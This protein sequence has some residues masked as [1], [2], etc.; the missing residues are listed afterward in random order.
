QAAV[1]QPASVD[2]SLGGTAKIDCSGSSSDEHGISNYGWWQ[3][4]PSGTLVALIY[5]N[6]KRPSGIPARF[7]GSYSGSTGT[8]TI[9]G[10]QAEDEVVYY[11]SGSYDGVVGDTEHW[12]VW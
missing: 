1:T 4:I 8:L 2:V 12:W 6:N 3:Q 11:C 10:V 7:S 9:T 5:E